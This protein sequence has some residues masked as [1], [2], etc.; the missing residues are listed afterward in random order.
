[1][2]QILSNFFL[3][4]CI[5]STSSMAFSQ[6]FQGNYDVLLK[7]GR[8]TFTDNIEDFINQS[9]LTTFEQKESHFYRFIQFND[10]PTETQLDQIANSGLRLLEYIPHKTYI[11]AIPTNM[12][13]QLLKTLNVRAVRKIETNIKLDQYLQNQDYSTAQVDDNEIFLTVR[14]YEPKNRKALLSALL[15]LHAKVVNI[16][17]RN[18]LIKIKIRKKDEA[19]KAIANLPFVSYVEIVSPSSEP[20]DINGRSLQKSNMLNETAANGVKYNGEGIKVLVRDDGPVGPHIDFQGRLEMVGNVQPTGTAEHADGVAG[21][22]AGAGNLDPFVEAGATGSYIYVTNQEKFFQDT[23]YGLH[24]Y[25]NVKVTNTSYSYSNSCNDG[26]TTTTQTVDNQIWNSKTLMHIFSAGNRNN[27]TCGSNAY[28]AGDQWGNITGGHKIG[29]N[30]ITTANL[31]GI[32]LIQSS[33]SRGPASDGRIK[34]DMSAYGQGQISTDPNNTYKSF[35]GT[36]AAAPSGAGTFAMLLHAYKDMNAGQEAESGLIKAAVMNTARDLGNAGADF[37]YGWG[38][39]NGGR[40]YNLLKDNRYTTGSVTQGTTTNH[41][42]TI[43]ANVKEARVMVYWMEPEGS[44]VSAIALVN[45]L[46]MTVTDGTNTTQPLVLNSAPNATTLDNPAAPGIDNL[47]NVEQVRLTNPAAG[48]YTVNV[49]GSVAPFG[50]VQYYVL[51]EYLTEEIKVTYPNGGEGLDPNTV[52]RIHWDAH[53]NNGTFA[54]HYSTNSGTSW[55]LI[56]SSV[57]SSSRLYNWN[58]PNSVTDNAMIRVT[59]GSFADQS[60]TTFSIIGTPTGIVVDTVCANSMT[61]SWNAVPNATSYDVMVLG[62]KYMDSI[63]TS[64]TTTSS[65]LSL[66]S[67]PNDSYWISVRARINDGVGT[68]ANAVYYPGGLLNCV[69]NDEL[70]LLLISPSGFSTSC[71]ADSSVIVE[72]SNHGLNA[73]TNISVSYQLDNNAIVTETITSPLAVGQSINYTFNTLL[74]ITT[75]IQY[76]L[77]TWVNLPTDPLSYNDT[78]SATLEFFSAFS[79]PYTDDFETYNTCGTSQ[80]CG[81]EICPLGNGW[82]NNENGLVDNIDWRVDA[83]GTPSGGTGP[84]VDHSTGTS[85]GNYLYLE[86]SNGCSGQIAELVTPCIDLTAVSFPVFSL[87]YHMEGTSVGELHVDILSKCS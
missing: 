33:S 23:T 29:K 56:T 11:A 20:D 79:A 38:L 21:V 50:A 87:W 19:I 8:I 10:I 45:D 15:G 60:D 12:N 7:S 63:A 52:A 65:F 3:I 77:K 74:P 67:N 85:S 80:N 82:V 36:S 16:H 86:A 5:V 72:V 51:Y 41:S 57:P 31:N 35:G 69:P 59:R 6:K 55:N 9:N 84:T 34:P 4:I 42:F 62:D 66:T 61:V 76:D 71:I 83:G 17:Y 13:F 47:N 39:Y 78:S 64:T 73:Q 81:L 24:L 32:G 49:A 58:V 53:S 75:G 48:T 22:F 18:H 40:A 25:H 26:Y 2:K 70:S 46:D 30:A 1:M 54:L 68:R 27:N 44:T 14:L 28:G 43:P 37:K